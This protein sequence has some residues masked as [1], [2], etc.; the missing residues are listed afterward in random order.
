M[1]DIHPAGVFRESAAYGIAGDQIIGYGI[2]G[3]TIHALLW[4]TAGVVDLNPSG[5]VGSS[6]TATD[7]SQQVGYGAPNGFIGLGAAAYGNHAMLWS[8]TAESVVDLHPATGYE[9]T[10]ANGVGGGQQVGWGRASGSSHALLWTSSPQS[11]VDLHPSGARDTAALGVANGRQVGWGT[12]ADGATHAL[13]WN[14]TAESVVDLHLLLPA[15][16]TRSDASGID[17]SGNIIG[18]AMDS[19]GR[20][21][22]ILWVRQ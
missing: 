8:G 3:I 6:G 22:A 19:T 10:S 13:V 12:I 11:V 1:V 16:Y 21:H 7:G 15:G 14:G 9:T 20:S 4:T 17:A 5:F 18:S 2:T